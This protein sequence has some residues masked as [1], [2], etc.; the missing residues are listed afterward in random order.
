MSGHAVRAH[1]KLSASGSDRWLSCP[2][3][4]NLEDMFPENDS[5]VFAEEG[6]FAHELSELHL[7]FLLQKININAH[8]DRLSAMKLN[9]YYSQDM[10]EHVHSY[11]NIV[12]ER[13]N[14]ARALT[15]DAVVLL[16]QKLDFSPWVEDGYGTGDVVIIADGILEIIDLKFGKGVEVSAE[17]NSQLRLYGLGALNGF[18]FLYDVQ[19]IQMTIVQP[20]L[21]NVSTEE[22][23][24]E[25]LLL[26][27]EDV[28]RPGAIQALSGN[29]AIVP[30]DHCKFCKARTHCR[31][32]AMYCLELEA[33]EFKE[34]PM[35]SAEEIGEVLAKADA[36][37]SWVT[38]I[39]G[40]ALDQAEN[41]GVKF[42]GW[43]LVEGRSN[44][45]YTN[46][47]A[48]AQTLIIEGFDAK[49]IYEPQ[50]ILGITAMEKQIGK[51]QFTALLSEF[52]IKPTGKPTLVEESDKRP[53]LSS[54]D[55][56]ESDFKDVV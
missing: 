8:D 25:E 48:I 10:E 50:E 55:S 42:P 35:L 46:K 39:T 32:R 33:L 1:A 23:S 37:K 9:P 6:T 45:V 13:I 31:A 16:E 30:G 3:S 11:V 21:D 4:V 27:A 44:R 51:K 38:D 29:G 43:K 12:N 34:A 24:A 36:L 7:S 17:N 18:G 19:S 15:S 47:E 26:W 14:A 2:G 28:I 52:I 49:T 41:H 56:I 53:E 54:M 40:Y 5:S 22:L 20:R